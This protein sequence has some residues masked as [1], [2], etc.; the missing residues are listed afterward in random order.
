[1]RN[2]NQLQTNLRHW[3]LNIRLKREITEIRRRFSNRPTGM[4]LREELAARF[5][6]IDFSIGQKDQQFARLKATGKDFWEVA[7]FQ[8]M[9]GIGPIGAHTLRLTFKPPLVSFPRK[10]LIGFC[11]LAVA[12]GSS[13]GRQYGREH[14]DK[15]SHSRPKQVSYIAWE[16]ALKN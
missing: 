12:K 4:L 8:K 7:E 5:F 14:L 9:A 10:Q 11:Q 15:T 13:D 3:E 1:M 6:R 16:T 2:K